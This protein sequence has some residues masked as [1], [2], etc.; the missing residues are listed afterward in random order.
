MA[1]TGWWW[2]QWQK[3]KCWQQLH[4]ILTATCIADVVSWVFGG[5]MMTATQSWSSSPSAS[6]EAPGSSFGTWYYWSCPSSSWQPENV[7][8][9]TPFAC[10]WHISP[11]SQPRLYCPVNNPTIAPVPKSHLALKEM[12]IKATEWHGRTQSLN[13]AWPAKSS[14]FN[15]YFSLSQYLASF[16]ICIFG[17]KRG[18]LL[19]G[20]AKKWGLNWTGH[21]LYPWLQER[22]KLDDLQQS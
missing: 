1:V 21:L 2:W 11:S 8:I 14:L 5:G 19:A 18:G 3:W 17:W 4:I 12:R 9:V 16:L 15:G 13:L 20:Q 10:L 22:V 6:P 7:D